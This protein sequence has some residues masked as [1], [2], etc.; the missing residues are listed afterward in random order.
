MYIDLHIPIIYTSL[1]HILLLRPKESQGIPQESV[2]LKQP[3][4]RR[5]NSQCIR[6][7]A[8]PLTALPRSQPRQEKA[9]WLMFGMAMGTYWKS[10]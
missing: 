2:Q 3:K 8:R 10:I 5:A 4:A 9:E 6:S 7:P 1:D